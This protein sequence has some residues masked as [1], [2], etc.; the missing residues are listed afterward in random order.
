MANIQQTVTFN[1]PKAYAG[2]KYGENPRRSI[3]G[4]ASGDIEFGQAVVLDSSSP[5]INGRRNLKLPS[6]K[7]DTFIGFAEQRHI[8]PNQN[9]PHTPIG[10]V[11]SNR[12]V[13][14]E[15]YDAV[16]VT[17][18]GDIW[19]NA[20]EAVAPTDDVYVRFLTTSANKSVGYVR[21]D[22]D[23][24][25][26]DNVE[27]ASNVG[28]LTSASDHELNVG[29]TVTIEGLTTTDLN[30]MFE[31][32]SVPSSTTFTVNVTAD[33]VASTSDSGTIDRA[34]KVSD[35]EFFT[36]TSGADLVVVYLK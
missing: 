2:G 34:F 36:S 26:I 18:H 33:D 4:I 30:G 7:N 17:A 16:P 29:D 12:K 32:Q 10:Q 24:I 21:S 15:N 8:E 9:S 25:T 11:S 19:V 1:Y 35:A 13:N 23:Q 6:S 20:E 31:V 22:A 3:T 14:W 5:L 27:I 28:T